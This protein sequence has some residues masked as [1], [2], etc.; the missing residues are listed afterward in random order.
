MRFIQFLRE[1]CAVIELLEMLIE[2]D[3]INWDP[4]STKQ[5]KGVKGI[6]GEVGTDRM[7]KPS[8]PSAARVKQGDIVVVKMPGGRP[9]VTSVAAVDDHEAMVFNPR[10]GIKKKIPK[11]AI[12]RAPD[13]VA[14]MMHDKGVTDKSF[15]VFDARTQSTDWL[16][17]A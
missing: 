1:D 16:P 10:H 17:G 5:F 12:V 9:Y 8:A 15:W 6:T 4:E 14:Q 2:S 11:N 3:S 7:V 13:S